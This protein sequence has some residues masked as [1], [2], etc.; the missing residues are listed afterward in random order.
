MALA[1]GRLVAGASPSLIELRPL[2]ARPARLRRRHRMAIL[3]QVAAALGP[4]RRGGPPIVVLA[5]DHALAAARRA[6]GLPAAAGEVAER[7]VARFGTS[8][9][10]QRASAVVPPGGPVGDR[11]CDANRLRRCRGERGAC[12]VIRGTSSRKL[13]IRRDGEPHR[14]R[15]VIARTFRRI[16]DFRGIATRQD[17]TARRLL[18]A[19]SRFSS[20]ASRGPP[21]GPQLARHAN[22]HECGPVASLDGCFYMQVAARRGGGVVDRVGLENR[23]R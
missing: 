15:D 10:R 14:L 21:R 8:V 2:R 18:A 1:G 12:A 17:E 23:S 22:S 3:R 6:G 4:E 7:A 5:V 9:R 19:L 13:A 16:G 11:G 20:N